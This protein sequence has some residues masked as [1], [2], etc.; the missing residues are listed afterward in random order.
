ML[1]DVLTRVMVTDDPSHMTYVAVGVAFAVLLVTL[2]AVAI[3]FCPKRGTC[4]HARSASSDLDINRLLILLI[5]TDD[6][7]CRPAAAVHGCAVYTSVQTSCPAEEVRADGQVDGQADG[8]ADAPNPLYLQRSD[9]CVGATWLEGTF[10]VISKAALRTERAI[11]DVTVK[12]VKGSSRQR[13]PIETYRRMACLR[14]RSSFLLS[15]NLVG[16]R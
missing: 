4:F 14:L 11:V 5:L 9:V 13:V 8:Q 3:F 15:L 10:G 2:T 7:R 1:G 6:W 16:R 12:T